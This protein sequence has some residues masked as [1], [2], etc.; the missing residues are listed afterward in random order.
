TLP[1]VTGEFIYEDGK[2][3]ITRELSFPYSAKKANGTLLIENVAIKNKNGN[4]KI[5]EPK[6][7]AQGVLLT[8]QL[9]V[10]NQTGAFA[11]EGYTAEDAG[12]TTFTFYFEPGKA[13]L[14][15]YTGSNLKALHDFIASNVATQKVV[16]T[17]SHS[18]EPEE[19]NQPE[20]AQQRAQALENYYRQQLDTYAYLK[21]ND[22]V[23]FVTVTE[24]ENWNLFLKKLQQSALK[25]EQV[26]QILEVLN[27]DTSYNAIHQRLQQLDA[28]PYLKEYVFPMLRSAEVKITHTSDRRPD[29]EIFLLSKKITE[30]K[31]DADALTEEELRYAAT[32][33]PLLSEKQKIYEAAVKNNKNWQAYNNLGMVYLQMAKKEVNRPRVRKV[34]L[35]KAINNLTYGSHRNPTAQTFYNLA[36]AYYMQGKLEQALEYYNYTIRLG[37]PTPVL[38]QIF[39]DKAA[40]EIELGLYDHALNS[41]AYA[42]ESFQTYMNRGLA[43]MLKGYKEEAIQQYEM[44]LELEPKNALAHYSLAI[45]GARTQNEQLLSENLK[46]AIKL[47]PAFTQ[48]AIEDLEFRDYR[49]T[50]V[51]EN[52]LIEK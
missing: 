11:P 48:R 36:N 24:N 19:L 22:T 52:A 46:S 50:E 9:I 38:Q 20:L 13:A 34:L 40:V 8:P 21:Q 26:N 16:I 44:A 33:T 25:P 27:G 12:K 14:R 39:A 10:R 51:F 7:V 2:P 37:G 17:A 29:Y 41:L 35:E 43:Y 15:Q 6:A 31:A 45:L 4:F 23:K 49:K 47:N 42:G 3:T 30:N 28:Y 5:S 18:P 1:F 32:L